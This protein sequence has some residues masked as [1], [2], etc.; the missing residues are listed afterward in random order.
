MNATTST[1]HIQNPALK[2]R[3]TA[4][5][6]FAD[7]AGGYIVATHWLTGGILAALAVIAV[8]G[9][10]LVQT[11]RHY[12]QW[13]PLVLREYA[14]GRVDVQSYDQA[15]FRA[16]NTLVQHFL[17][18]FVELHFTRQSRTALE[19][20]YTNSLK[21][22]DPRLQHVPIGLDDTTEA[23]QGFIRDRSAKEI[24]VVAKKVTLEDVRQ[25]GAG[26]DARILGGK[27]SVDFTKVYVEPTN[28]NARTTKTFTAQILFDVLTDVPNHFVPVN[29]IGL[30]ISHIRVD[31]SF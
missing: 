13:K 17:S 26:S 4:E 14:D 3:A 7:Y 12:A 22:L 9:W 29:P 15:T 16:T 18:R 24:E 20:D 21:F 2:T 10:L 6:Q 25:A 23:M 30:Q 28:T 27:A 1:L 8:L 11:Q 31:E 5:R 19:R